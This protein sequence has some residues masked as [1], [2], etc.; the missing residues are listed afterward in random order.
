MKNSYAVSKPRVS[1][2][3]VYIFRE[4]ELFDPAQP[5]KWTRLDYAPNYILEFISPELDDIM[6]RV[7]DTLRG[8]DHLFRLRSCSRVGQA[9]T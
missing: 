5:L 3:W 2:T 4:A 7:S 8:E 9:L 6:D 1:C